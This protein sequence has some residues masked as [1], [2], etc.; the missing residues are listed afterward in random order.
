L[1]LKKFF[2]ICNFLDKKKTNSPCPKELCAF[3]L[4]TQLSSV[5]VKM[6]HPHRSRGREEGIGDLQAGRE[7]PGKGDNI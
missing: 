5:T 1:H 4:S 6:E 3:F 7:G 2:F